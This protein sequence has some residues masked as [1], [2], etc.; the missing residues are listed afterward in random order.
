MAFKI[1]RKD[2][3]PRYVVPLVDNFE[4]VGE[5]PIDLTTLEKVFFI[6]RTKGEEGGEPEIKE[7]AEVLGDPKDGVVQYTWQT[8]DTDTTGNFNVEFELQWEDGGIETVPNE[9]FFEVVV[10]AD[11]G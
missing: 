8:G 4:E 9:S 3:R 1:K 11:L 2:T 6:M 5:A 7:E 10:V